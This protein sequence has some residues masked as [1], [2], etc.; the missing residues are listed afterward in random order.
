MKA[1]ILLPLLFFLLIPL[2]M[3]F[4]QGDIAILSPK[5]GEGVKGRIIIS[6]YIKATNATRYDLDFAYTGQESSGWQPISSA[7]KPAEDGT[8]GI[9]DT[10]AISDGNYTLRLR[11]YLSDG[12]T[13]DHQVENIRVRNYSAMETSTPAAGLAQ[14][15]APTVTAAAVLFPDQAARKPVP[16][17][18]AAFTAPKFQLNLVVAILTGIFLAILLAYFFT[19]RTSR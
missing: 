7:E 9:W 2:Q 10:S 18:P 19:S 12:Q 16:A 17:N 13:S 4:A 5:G 11:V 6:G 3:V 1:K 14:N 8:L 15:V